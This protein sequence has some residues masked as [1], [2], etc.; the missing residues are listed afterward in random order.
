VFSLISERVEHPLTYPFK[1]RLLGVG[2][3]RREHIDLSRSLCGGVHDTV[4]DVE[5]V[6]HVLEVLRI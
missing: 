2:A 5:A 6:G 4:S 1:E 3:G